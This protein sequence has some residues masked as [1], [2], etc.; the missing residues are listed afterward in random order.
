MRVILLKD[1]LNIGAENDI[2]EVADGFARNFLF[3]KNL[4]RQATTRA[5]EELQRKKAEQQKQAEHDLKHIQEMASAIDGF[6]LIIPAR[7]AEQGGKLFAAITP[8]SVSDAL[9][10]QGYDIASQQMRFVPIKT[11][12]EY[13]VLISFEH[14]LEAHLKVICEEIIE[15]LEE[16]P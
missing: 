12:G 15:P 2:V 9:K 13:P 6:E 14:G 10:Q 1:V 11:A 7:A 16:L 4:A 8:R 5:L 3:P